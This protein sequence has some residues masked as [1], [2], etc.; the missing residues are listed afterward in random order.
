MPLLITTHKQGSKDNKAIEVNTVAKHKPKGVTSWCSTDYI[1]EGV[2][3]A[4]GM[5]AGKYQ[6]IGRINSIDDCMKS[7]CGIE[8]C[9]VAFLDRGICYAVTCV[10]KDTCKAVIADSR[11]SVGYVIRNG[12]SLFKSVQ[13]AISDNKFSPKPTVGLHLVPVENKPSHSQN[14][15]EL[16]PQSGDETAHFKPLYL[17]GG[18]VEKVDLNRV[19]SGETK[20]A[21]G[22]KPV[23]PSNTTAVNSTSTKPNLNPF[24]H[25]ESSQGQ[26]FGYCE[27][28]ETIENH[29][30]MGGMKAGV[31]TDHGEVNDLETCTEYCCKDRECHLAYMVDKSCYSVKCYNSELC[32]T[33]QAPH[34]FLNPVMAFVSRTRNSSGNDVVFFFIA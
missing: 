28:K 29:R 26:D 7:C 10:D 23:P 5:N 2:K 18:R 20:S 31:F 14:S 13:D 4:G 25:P 21:N 33:F 8:N 32:T 6:Q 30:L 22:T 19:V 15:D 17:P 11:T 3:L 12:W 16:V 1:L 34:F 24:P 27:K 9:T